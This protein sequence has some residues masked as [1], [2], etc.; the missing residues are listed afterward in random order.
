MASDNVSMGNSL[1]L[2]SQQ[3]LVFPD[4]SPRSR[5]NYDL[6]TGST[7]EHANA[8]A[9]ANPM[10]NPGIPSLRQGRTADD[11]DNLDDEYS[12]TVEDPAALFKETIFNIT[13]TIKTKLTEGKS[14]T[15]ANK[16]T[17]F[18]LLID[19][20]L[21]TTAY[22][23]SSAG[24][25][26]P[27]DSTALDRATVAVIKDTIKEEVSKIQ[28]TVERTIQQK[29]IG[30]IG[31]DQNT[32]YAS[33]LKNSPPKKS[34]KINIPTT[35]PAIIVGPT[36][37]VFSSAQTHEIIKKNI[38][39]RDQEFA[40]ENVRYVSNNKVLIEF[41]KPEYAEITL[42]M[43]K[44]TDCPIRAEKSKKLKPMFILKGVSSEIAPEELSELITKQNELIKKVTGPEDN[45]VFKFKRNNRNES[46]Y[47]AVFMATPKIWRAVMSAGKLNVDHQRVHVDEYVPLLQCYKCLQF[48]HTRN[49]CTRDDAV[50][51]HC[52]A[53]THTYKECPVKRDNNKLN[54]YNCEMHSKRHNVISTMTNHSA[55]SNECPKVYLMTEKLRTRID[56]GY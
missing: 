50:C 28:R 15:K 53:M 42:E 49:K 27:A 56:Y 31:K 10:A 5:D 44:N 7:T 37:E 46:L 40:P 48:G 17:I 36:T 1:D 22:L 9:A 55:T 2:G 11:E 38:S 24:S 34:E 51:S 43:I 4:S 8:T 26:S 25:S 19:I 35:K 21:E 32:T 54:C 45:L 18:Q 39:F 29:T 6:E 3:E 13:K 30:A 16:E 52:A 33:K 12:S 20:Q 14:L 23:S 47:N 41:D